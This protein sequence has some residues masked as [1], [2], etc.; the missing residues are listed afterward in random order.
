MW[1]LRKFFKVVETKKKVVCEY[2]MSVNKKWWWIKI[3]CKVE[4]HNYDDN[5]SCRV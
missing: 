2:E 5:N 4:S 3:K 1:K